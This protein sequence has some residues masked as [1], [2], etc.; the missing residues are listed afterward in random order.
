MPICKKWGKLE[1]QLGERN[2]FGIYRGY[3]SELKGSPVIIRRGVVLKNGEEILMAKS[4]FQKF[5]EV[6]MDF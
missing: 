3:L 4:K 5:E 2:F 6:Y 1:E